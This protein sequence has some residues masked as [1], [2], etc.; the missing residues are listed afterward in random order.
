MVLGTIVS[1]ILSSIALFF[2]HEEKHIKNVEE[3]ENY[4]KHF[5]DLI[6]EIKTN[7]VFR[8]LLLYTIIAVGMIY[9]MNDFNQLYYGEIK[10]PL[11]IIG[12]II[13][14]THILIGIFSIFA[15]RLQKIKHIGSISLLITFL[16]LGSVGIFY[17]T[18]T[19]IPLIF[20]NILIAGPIFVL[21]EIK[22]QK[23]IS[24][25][26]RATIMSSWQVMLELSTIIFTLLTG[27]IGEIYG[28]NIAFLTLGIILFIFAFWV[29]V[30]DK[31]YNIN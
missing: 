27:F 5:K 24:T 23:S 25:K 29:I 20:S 14:I 7:S 15:Y 19:I 30:K 13:A 1:A 4:F 18:A 6:K 26:S 8:F 17:N 3:E 12:I 22:I 28:L 9:N 2:M 16:C 11:P 10:I 31:K 21:V